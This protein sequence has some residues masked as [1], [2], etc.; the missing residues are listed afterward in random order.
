M[1]IK[2]SFIATPKI[3]QLVL[4]NSFVV[5]DFSS[6]GCGANYIGKTIRTL[7]ERTVAHAWT[8]NNSAVYKHLDDCTAVQHLP[9]IAPFHSS[10]FTSSTP[11]N[12]SDKFDLRTTQINLAQDNTE[13]I[14]RHKNWVF[15]CLKRR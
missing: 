9:D 6:P 7:Y 5:Y 10:L 2:L 8:D 4:S 3:K 14:D 1:L 13:I 11:I 15:F 12:N